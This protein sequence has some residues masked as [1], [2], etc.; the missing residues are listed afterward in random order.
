MINNPCRVCYVFYR[1]EPEPNFENLSIHALEYG[2]DVFFI[3][4]S[5]KKK[6]YITEDDNRRKFLKIHLKNNQKKIRSLEFI[7]KAVK[8]INREKKHIYN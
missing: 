8:I 6:N 4:F 7:L 5:S 3:T 2:L 1:N